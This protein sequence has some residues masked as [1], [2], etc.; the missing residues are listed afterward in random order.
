M[1]AVVLLIVEQS[2]H[3]LFKEALGLISIQFDLKVQ[4]I[5]VSHNVILKRRCTPL[6]LVLAEDLIS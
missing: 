2:K 4:F 3:H 5:I 1:I 6:L